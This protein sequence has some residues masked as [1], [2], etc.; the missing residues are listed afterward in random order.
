MQLET[1]DKQNS[2]RA[3]LWRVFLWGLVLVG[4]GASLFA[5]AKR[6][7]TE[8]RNRAVEIVLDFA[9]VREISAAEGKTT[10]DVLNRFKRAGVSSIALQEDTI[11][12]LAEQRRIEILSTGSLNSFNMSVAGAET[13]KR[14]M[15]A[16][17]AKVPGGYASDVSDPIAVFLTV[18][19]PYTTVRS[20]GVG[21][22]PRN[23]AQIKKAGLQVVGRVTNFNSATP[24]S[25]RW[26][27]ENLK[28]S[29]AHS[30]LF[31]GEDVLGYK[32]FLLSDPEKP[33]VPSTASV[34][35]EL[36]MTVGIVEFTKM[37]GMEALA[38]PNADI[39]V[40]LHTMTG[41]EMFN[42]E[43]P[44]AL[45]RFLL[46]ARERNIRQLFVRMFMAESPLLD[47]NA[48]FIED[49]V[50]G[51]DR[52]NLVPGNAHSFQPLSTPLW[53]RALIG[54]GV[55]SAFLLLVT[56]ILGRVR[57]ITGFLLA[58][59]AVMLVTLPCLSGTLGV[60]LSAFAA[61]CIYPS[62]ALLCTDWLRPR[63]QSRAPI[64]LALGRFFVICAITGLGIASIVGLL[65]DR[66]FL[67]KADEFA[68]IKAAQVVPLILV[69]LVVG[70]NWRADIYRTFG[71]ATENLRRRALDFIAQPIVYWQ[72]LALVAGLVLFILMLDRSGNDSGVG[73]SV[74]ELKL[75][76]ILDRFLYARP[77]FKEFLIGHPALLLSL[78][79]GVTGRRQ[80]AIPLFIIGAVGQI[81]LLNTFCHLH[82]PLL[83]GLWRAG[84]G[85]GFGILIGL[86]FYA[87]IA[88]FTRPG[89]PSSVTPLLGNSALRGR[90]NEGAGVSTDPI[91]AE[92]TEAGRN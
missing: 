4:L 61:G 35:N 12:G 89:K 14:V 91:D 31:A 52:G 3:A 50:K 16:L 87:L 85:I 77:R 26:T 27:L 73:V 82:T 65:A 13:V 55:G 48:T 78:I 34:L 49:I 76:A 79:F 69:F 28:A 47:T 44:S 63:H 60:K 29:G 11:A 22:E 40:R 88:L 58:V 23:I 33:S 32:K 74:Y 71:Q 30:V 41:P 7:Q 37:K 25:I 36:G 92:K 46:A 39:A 72:L 45:Q 64:L 19:A 62:L 38:K 90:P 43:M 84:L 17:K 15:A 68:G 51:L 70:L 75:R 5:A 66:L 18:N 24:Q 2:R 54:I 20:L 42:A 81:S 57:G 86:V 10:A 8:T 67:I 21:L 53:N 56:G 9:E 6:W 83:V 1:D 59:I 80:W